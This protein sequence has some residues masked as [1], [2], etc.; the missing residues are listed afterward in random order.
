VTPTRPPEQI[1]AHRLTILYVLALGTVA[2]LCIAGQILIQQMI[3]QQR[4]DSTVINVAGRQRMLSQQISKAA[5]ALQIADSAEAQEARRK[6]LGD[7]LALWR[8]SHDAL[9]ERDGALGIHGENSEDVRQMFAALEEARAALAEAG[10]A[11]SLREVQGTPAF[12]EALSAILAYEATFLLAMDAIVFQYEREATARVD[13]L[14]QAEWILLCITL[15]VLLLEAL[16]IFRPVVKSIRRAFAQL[17]AAETQRAAMAAELSAIFDSV[18][19]LILYHDKEGKIIRV[20]R[21]GAEIIGESLYK[22]HGSS[23]YELFPGD[24][25]R[26]EEEDAW[27]YAQDTPRLGLLHAI[28]NSQGDIRWLRMNKVPYRDLKQQV[29][30][31]IIFAVDVS[32]HK[33]LERRL[34]ELRANEERRL[35]Y[36]LHDGLGQHLSGILYLGRRLENR[37]R[38]KGIEEADN[39]GEV[40]KLVKESVEMVRTLS[41]GLSPLGDEPEALSRALAELATK[42]RDTIGIECRFEEKGTVLVFERDMAEHLYRIAQEGVNNALRHSEATAIHIRLEQGDDETVLEIEDNGIGLPEKHLRRA[43]SHGRDPE[44]LGMG[45]ME[46]R[47]E[48]LGGH[49]E[50]KGAEG[51]GVR[52]RCSVKL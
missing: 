6:E 28:R 1:F 14:R 34:M 10:E 15:V 50:V 8:L 44:G 38:N 42:T 49:F 11:L 52:I 37:L 45:I 17:A 21:S 39:A 29:I 9:T 51:Q 12:G 13:R 41:K 19:A 30:G 46:H 2:I 16:F 33:R 43:R 31:I 20:N 36:D 40:V 32:A 26:F 24:T 4:A 5:L 7:A 47:A 27:I 18:P 3:G 48:L 25:S 23:V 22:L 35:G